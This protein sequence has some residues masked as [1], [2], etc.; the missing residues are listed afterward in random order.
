MARPSPSLDEALRRVGDRWTLL[1]VSALL[2]GPRR[3]GELQEAVPDVATN[4][5][6]SRLRRLE[7]HGLVISR[8]YSERPVRVEYQLS[9]AATELSGVLRMLSAW[10]GTVGEEPP[11]V[12]QECGTP[13][14][15]RYFC[16]TCQ[17]VADDSG[18][19]LWV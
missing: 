15:I 5:L 3:F 10:E 11:P 13:L 4:I 17:S 2:D 16:P 18:D 9:R 1:I 14:E 19:W 6:A 8:P 7:H 12:H